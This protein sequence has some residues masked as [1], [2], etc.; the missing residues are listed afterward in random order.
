MATQIHNSSPDTKILLRKQILEQTENPVV[1]DAFSGPGKM[2]DAVYSAV[3]WT[4]VDK[5]ADSP[6]AIHADNRDILKAVSLDKYNF[7][8]LDAF[9]CPWEQVWIISQRRSCLPLSLVITDGNRGGTACITPTIAAAGWSKQMADAIKVTSDT[10]HKYFCSKRGA[11]QTAQGLILA[12]YNR[13][14]I[15]TWVSTSSVNGKVW[16]FGLT[17]LPK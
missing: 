14:Y 11:E 15:N 2:R 5:D 9:G 4:G 7:F 12:W 10:R 13:H 8:D 3:D 16:Y 1:F 6:D 17:L